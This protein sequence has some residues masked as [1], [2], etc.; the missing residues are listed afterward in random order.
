M[1]KLKTTKNFNKKLQNLQQLFNLT[2]SDTKEI[3]SEIKEVML[4][5]EKTG[6]IP[7]EYQD[8]KLT[9][10]PWTGYNEFHVLDD[11]LVIYFKIEKKKVIRM[12]TITNH[13]ELQNGRW[14]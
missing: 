14:N 5:L 13:K 7:T 6:S 11:L 1:Y 10:A 2:K 9:R 8:H 4:E 3:I 12:V